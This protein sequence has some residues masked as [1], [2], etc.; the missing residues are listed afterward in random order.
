MPI[1]GQILHHKDFLFRDGGKGNKYV[2][3]LNTGDNDRPCLVIKTTSKAK[4]YPYATPGCNSGKCV[5]LI[6]KEC[7]QDFP[8]DTYLQLDYIYS[9]DV[10]EQLNNNKITFTGHLSTICF[11]NLKKCLRNFRA[12]IPQKHW[13]IIYS[14]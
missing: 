10:Q 4:H 12:D 2:I 3:V 13:Q 11:N 7:E 8:I 5:Y 14:S 1:A 6:L 9:V